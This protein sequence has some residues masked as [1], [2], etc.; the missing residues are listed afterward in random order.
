ML[1]VEYEMMYGMSEQLRRSCTAMEAARTLADETADAAEI[2][3]IDKTVADTR[4]IIAKV[5]EMLKN[6][7][8]STL[9]D[10]EE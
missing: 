4:S 2:A 5:E 3:Q 1:T 8:K 6:I 10:E 7:D 9:I